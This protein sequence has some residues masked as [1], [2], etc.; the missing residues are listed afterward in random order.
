MLCEMC[1][2]TLY[3]AKQAKPINYRPTLF[4]L[5]LTRLK[6]NGFKNLVDVDIR[7]GP[8]TC[9]A[10]A[11]GVGKSNLFDAIRFLSDLTQ[12]RL[13]DAAKSVRSEGQKNS[14]IRDLFYKTGNTHS[15]RMRFEADMIIP[16]SGIDDFGQEAKATITTV[17]YSLELAYRQGNGLSMQGLLEIVEETLIPISVTEARKLRFQSLD[18]LPL[19]KQREQ[20]SE[21]KKWQ[22]SVFTDRR[23]S[24]PF[25][26][27]TKKDDGTLVVN[28]HQDSSSQDGGGGGLPLPSRAATLIRTV[29]SSANATERPTALLAKNEMR[30]WQLLQLEP[31]ALRRSDDFN[32]VANAH[33]GADGSHLPA[34]LFRLN[35]ETQQNLVVPDV[36]QAVAGRLSELIEQVS[37]ID[38]DRDDKREMLTLM[39]TRRD[40]T[41]FPARALSDGTLRFL[42]LT[43]LELDYKSGG[44]VCL[45]EPENGIHPLKIAAMLRLLQDISMDTLLPVGT[46]NPLRQVIINTHSPNVV[47]LVPADSL[48]VAQL[49]ER[50]NPDGGRS[51]YVVYQPMENTWRTKV[52]SSYTPLSLGQLLA[53]LQT[54]VDDFIMPSTENEQETKTRGYSTNLG[55]Y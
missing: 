14:D 17:R 16:A 19:T 31:T 35:L 51:Q 25:I 27:T 26:S 29:L 43:V 11:N 50:V 32:I 41:T 15:P 46:D 53:Y 22:D 52:D 54:S 4:L 40:K 47:Q 45:E 3:A 13:E 55:K 24:K 7:F 42:A 12:M 5:M 39:L 21:E 8:F 37:A 20:R 36:Y 33:L 28:F 34:T 6:V 18:D 38:V 30:S 49:R 44:V 9:I 48:L 23:R 10:G 1:M 2:F